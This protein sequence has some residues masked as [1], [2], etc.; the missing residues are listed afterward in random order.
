MTAIGD[1]DHQPLTYPIDQAVFE[2]DSA[3]PDSRS[4][5]F[6]GL[7]FSDTLVR[8]LHRN[9]GTAVLTVT[10]EFGPVP[11]MPTL[12]FTNQPVAIQTEISAFMMRTL[13]DRW[14]A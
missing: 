7:G 12:P 11:Y 9:P 1:D 6:Q 10:P 13:R 4:Y 2:A 14:L 8:V 5:M 3:A